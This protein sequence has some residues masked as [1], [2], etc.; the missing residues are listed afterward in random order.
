MQTDKNADFETRLLP[1]NIW[2]PRPID[3]ELFDFTLKFIIHNP[4]MVAIKKEN[5]YLHPPKWREH[6]YIASTKPTPTPNSHTQHLY[7][8]P[9]PK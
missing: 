1:S 3:S 4:H 2:I 5:G 7:Q 9:T 8:V 6:Q